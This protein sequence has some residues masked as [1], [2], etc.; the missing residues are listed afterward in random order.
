MKISNLKITEKIDFGVSNKI[1]NVQYF[2]KFNDF[3]NRLLMLAENS[4]TSS[5]CLDVMKKFIIGK[6]FPI[7]LE[8]IIVNRKEQNINDIFC[9]LAYDYALFGGCVLHCNY[10]ELYE[11]SEIQYVPFE[12]TRLSIS[13]DSGY[14]EKIAISKEWIKKPRKD[15]IEYIATFTNNKE[16]LAKKI[17]SQKGLNNF[18]GTILYAGNNGCFSYPDTIC[19]PIIADMST[20]AAISVIKNRNANNGFFPA[21]LVVFFES[22][23]ENKDNKEKAD[24]SELEFYTNILKKAQGSENAS[25]LI[26][27]TARSES[28]VPVVKPISG[29]NFDKS[30]VES[31]K[32]VQG[33]I[34]RRFMQ[35]PILRCED[36]SVGF[37]T[38]QMIEAY[39]FY[40][41]VTREYR[42]FFERLFK[43]VLQNYKYEIPQELITISK[44][45]YGDS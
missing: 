31:E 11:V 6:G 10:N 42:K 37:S 5:S 7:D 28:E 16:V 36:V 39:K 32:S 40:N 18:T 27:V 4:Q 2:D 1:L 23:G 19:L 20:E 12:H 26:A 9:L 21:A 15:K 14:V 34:G 41:S 33:N 22:T 29:E 38:E 24:D 35:P 45:E 13:D 17:E 25:N 30:F 44:L 8:N 43:K 3:P